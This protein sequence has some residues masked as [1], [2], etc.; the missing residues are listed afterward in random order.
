MTG[1]KTPQGTRGKKDL[2]QAAVPNWGQ[3]GALDLERNPQA[4]IGAQRQL[5]VRV[6]TARGRK[7]SSTR[8]L[9]RQLNDPYVYEANRLGYR[10]R[11]T[12]NQPPGA[13]PK[14]TTRFLFFKILNLS[15]ISINL[16]AARER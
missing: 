14:S 15:S 9:K 13:Q 12:C 6:K 16:K 10:S 5:T 2:G 4:N 11:A 8:W 1:S 3:K 7:P